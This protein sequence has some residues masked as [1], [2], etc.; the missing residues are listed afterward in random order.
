MLLRQSTRS[1]R[2]STLSSTSLQL[3]LSRTTAHHHL[4]RQST[5]RLAQM[6]SSLSETL[7]Y[8]V[9]MRTHRL[10]DHH[11][12][13]VHLL[14]SHGSTS[15]VSSVLVRHSYTSHSSE[16]DSLEESLTQLR[17]ASSMQL[18]HRL[19]VLLTS[20]ERLSGSWMT[21]IRWLQDSQSSLNL[22]T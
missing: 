6:L 3:T 5:R 2:F 1:S 20:A 22:T 16:L 15:T 18:F 14:S 4:L 21:T 13:Q 10:T 7:S 17:L 9:S 12:E 8:S 19:Q 11:A